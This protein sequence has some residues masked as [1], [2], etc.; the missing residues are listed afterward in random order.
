MKFDGWAFRLAVDFHQFLRV[1]QLHSFWLA[2]M[3]EAIHGL[4]RVWTLQAEVWVLSPFLVVLASSFA[5][6][7]GQT[8]GGLGGSQ[9]GARLSP[10]VREPLE[11]LTHHPGVVVVGQHALAQGHQEPE[12]LL[13]AAVEQEH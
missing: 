12:G 7:A 4:A 11:P 8:T 13:L 2:V 6:Q 3:W 10:S 1:A 5:A 9:P